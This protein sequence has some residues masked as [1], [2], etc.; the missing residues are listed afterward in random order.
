MGT[1]AV[2]VQPGRQ[3][4]PVFNRYRA[5]RKWCDEEF[6]PTCS[7]DGERDRGEKYEGKKKKQKTNPSTKVH[8]AS[9]QNET[10]NKE[11]I[12]MNQLS[13]ATKKTCSFLMHRHQVITK[14]FESCFLKRQAC[15]KG[16][17]APAI[18]IKTTGLMCQSKGLTQGAQKTQDAAFWVTGLL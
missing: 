17:T 2:D 6:I 8:S 1:V 11:G 4:D 18:T 14:T 7:R 13:C 16:W 12:P 10:N 5:V 15:K 3:Q 9:K